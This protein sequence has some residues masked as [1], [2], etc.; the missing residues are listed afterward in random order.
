VIKLSVRV[1]NLFPEVVT[2]VE[3]NARRHVSDFGRDGVRQAQA[4]VA[5]DTGEARSKITSR[6]VK[7]MEYEVVSLAPHSEYLEF[8]T[9]HTPPQPFMAPTMAV[10]GPKFERKMHDLV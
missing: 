5:M 7:D 2:R 4:R 9:V 1:T 3:N 6:R 8:G 10:E